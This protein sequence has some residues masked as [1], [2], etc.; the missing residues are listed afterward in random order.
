MKRTLLT[1]LGLSVLLATGCASTGYAEDTSA[2]MGFMDWDADRDGMVA[3]SEFQTG[4]VQNGWFNDVDRNRD[5]MLTNDEFAA[6]SAGWS[7]DGNAFATWDANRD[8]MIDSNEF[9]MG[10]FSTWDRNRDG[11][12]DENEF[13]AGD[14]WFD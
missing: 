14:G 12:L 8:G 1:T 3:R 5:G 11:M 7:I 2:D 13:V 6:A 9:G 4:Y 10:T